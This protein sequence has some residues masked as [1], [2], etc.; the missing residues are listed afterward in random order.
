MKLAY[1]SDR[2]M[3]GH[4]EWCELPE[5]S[6][7]FDENKIYPYCKD[8]GYGYLQQLGCLWC[9]YIYGSK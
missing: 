4:C 5:D 8:C 3:G 6:I 2:V 7:A 9:N 1:P